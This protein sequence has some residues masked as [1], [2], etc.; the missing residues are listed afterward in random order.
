MEKTQG[1]KRELQVKPLLKTPDFL[2][3]FNESVQE[4]AKGYIHADKKAGIF[5]ET[6]CTNRVIL[7]ICDG[8]SSL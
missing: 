4:V 1:K 2:M 7:E 6:L 8:F 5:G 3:S